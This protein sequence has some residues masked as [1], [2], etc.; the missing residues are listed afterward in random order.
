MAVKFKDDT[1]EKKT[2]KLDFCVMHQKHDIF[3]KKIPNFIVRVITDR[4][5]LKCSLNTLFQQLR[6]T[7]LS[8]NLDELFGVTTNFKQWIFVSYSY[9][10]EIQYYKMKK[11]DHEELCK[12]PKIFEISQT[13]EVLTKPSYQDIDLQNR[14]NQTSTFGGETEF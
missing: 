4:S 1:G 10:R 6:H 5:N 7:C 13:F 8:H 12:I 11:V 9:E 14:E 3:S 2:H